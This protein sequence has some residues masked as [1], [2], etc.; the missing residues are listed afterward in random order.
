[1][2]RDIWF[3]SDTHF[4]HAN[5]LN[6]TDEVGNLIRPGF[7]SVEDMNNT[8]IENWNA[9]VKP[10]DKIYHLGDVFFGPSDDYEKIHNQ[11]NGHKRLLWG[12]HDDDAHR[13]MRLFE[14]TDVIRRFDEFN[15]IC[16]HLAMHPF[17]CYNHRKKIRMVNVHGHIHQHNIDEPQYINISVEMTNYAPVHIDSLVQMVA[18]R[19]PLFNEK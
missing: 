13:L 1:M 4:N 3:I 14:K 9:S 17:S 15:F 7:S 12:N 6:F 18:E 11:L 19:I 5:I 8:M 10:Q 16:S 2:S